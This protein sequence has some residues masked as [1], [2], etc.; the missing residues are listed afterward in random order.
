MLGRLRT[1][2]SR[3][4]KKRPFSRRKNIGELFLYTILFSI[5]FVFFLLHGIVWVLPEWKTLQNSVPASCTILEN[6]IKTESR[7]EEKLFRPEIRI[8]FFLGKEK[9]VLWTLDTDTLTEGKGFSPD[10]AKAEEALARY[11]VGKTYDCWYPDGKPEAAVLERKTSIWGWYFL[12]IPICLMI[13]GST[14]IWWSLRHWSISE[15]RKA[16]L[17]AKKRPSPFISG[18]AP[19]PANLLPTVP[20]PKIINDSPGTYL[21][22]RLPVVRQASLR[23]FVL[24]VF[25]ILWNVVSWSVLIGSLYRFN[26]T[27]TDFFFSVLF[28]VFF[29]GFAGLFLVVWILHHFL[30]AF[31]IGPTILEI[32]D[33]PVYPGRRYR[34][35]MIQSGALRFRRLDLKIQCEEIARFRQG[36]DTITTRKEVY[37]RILFFRED[38]EILRDEPLKKELFLRLPLGAMHSMRLEHNEIAWKIV[39]D[40][41]LIGWPDLHC[42]TPIIV[43]PAAIT[44]R[45][46]E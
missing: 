44:E 3:K 35:I 21:S 12:A 7:G 11:E 28:G 6:R 8:S 40:A 25:T 16:V 43:N 31:G 9:Y 27:E 34:I 45:S 4:R 20:D 2:L 41:K 39:I 30:V 1:E 38:F 14:G 46:I 42:E 36:T 5:G 37:S 19:Q 32:S 17:S 13:F 10:R 33:H 23:L 29:C 24:A 18:E 26:G 15:E 22:F